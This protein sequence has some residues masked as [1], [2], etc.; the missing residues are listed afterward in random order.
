MASST[1]RW[2]PAFR[3]PLTMPQSLGRPSRLT[4]PL[5]RDPDRI[6]AR[7][8]V[9]GGAQRELR[10]PG[11]A[12]SRAMSATEPKAG[13]EATEADAPLGPPRKSGASRLCSPVQPLYD[14]HRDNSVGRRTKNAWAAPREACPPRLTL[15][16]GCGIRLATGQPVA[17]ATRKTVALLAY[18]GA[19]SR[20]AHPRRQ[21]GRAPSGAI[22]AR[23]R[24]RATACAT[25]SSASEKVLPHGPGS[26]RPDARPRPRGGVRG[27]RRVRSGGPPS[28][29]RRRFE[30][31]AALYG[32]DFLDGLA[33]STRPALRGMA[34][35]RA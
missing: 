6:R 2:S 14:G 7:R 25:R 26:P 11:L 19:P 3:W 9:R 18:L 8:K 12:S 31:A 24:Q 1:E 28:A 30:A 27:R 34:S 15:P 33:P 32:G 20:H 21:A 23:P 35:G 29:R 22:G 13:V 4:S 17:F 10:V 5:D 16:G